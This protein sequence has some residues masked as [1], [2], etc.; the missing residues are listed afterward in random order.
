MFAFHHIN[1]PGNGSHLIHIFSADSSA[2]ASAPCKYEV[3]NED[4]LT[5]RDV[6]QM[7][8]LLLY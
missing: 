3:E 4:E 1:R 2:L 6:H 5:E 8:V 7:N